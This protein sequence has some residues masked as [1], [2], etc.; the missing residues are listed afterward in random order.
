ME[1]GTFGK[2][3]KTLGGD[4]YRYGRRTMANA[5][6]I[7]R[8]MPQQNKHLGSFLHNMGNV[9]KDGAGRLM[10]RRYGEH[11]GGAASHLY[12]NRGKYITGAMAT[13][14]ALSWFGSDDDKE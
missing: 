9:T 4:I 11:V 5:P 14:V 12:N 7:G 3:L 1:D 6:I 8:Y 13:P 10:T 2:G